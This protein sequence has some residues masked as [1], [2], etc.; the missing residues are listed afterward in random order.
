MKHICARCSESLGRGQEVVQML[1][2]PWYDG[3]TPAFTELLGEWCPEC[4]RQEY[5][6]NS[7]SRPYECEEC[8][9]KILFGENIRFFIVGHET[10]AGNTVAENRGD[11]IYTV[12]HDPNCESARDVAPITQ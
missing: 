9:N 1:R 8:G 10:D 3:I 6:L 2:G 4:F 7:Q 12:K 11:A 5:S